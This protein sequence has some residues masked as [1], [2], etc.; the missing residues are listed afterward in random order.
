MLVDRDVLS[1]ELLVSQYHTAGSVHLIHILV[2]L[3]ELDH[4]ASCV[5]FVLIGTSLVLDPDSVID[6]EWW[7]LS[8]MFSQHSIVFMW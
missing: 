7:E 2:E 4:L 8:C 1:E 6:Y 3:S 5:Q